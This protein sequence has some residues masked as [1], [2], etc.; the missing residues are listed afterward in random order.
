LKKG[1]AERGRKVKWETL[2]LV[3]GTWGFKG[4]KLYPLSQQ[5]NEV[6]W[7]G[8]EMDENKAIRTN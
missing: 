7:G 4:G 8:K 1:R 2:K 3:N 6:I 5:K